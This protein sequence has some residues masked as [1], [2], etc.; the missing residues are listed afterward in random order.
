MVGAPYGGAD[1]R[2]AVYIYL[3]GADG[4]VAEHAQV[5]YARDVA[6]AGALR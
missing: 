2:G 4:V 6:R 5:I 3:G 1:G